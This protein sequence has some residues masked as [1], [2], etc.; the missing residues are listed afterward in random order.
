MPLLAQPLDEDA[1]HVFVDDGSFLALNDSMPL[2]DGVVHFPRIHLPPFTSGG[3]N[4]VACCGA[5]CCPLTSC[6][7]K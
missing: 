2:R 7:R 5:A 6:P 4:F 1:G 3:F